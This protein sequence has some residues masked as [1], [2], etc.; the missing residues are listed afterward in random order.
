ML[1]PPASWQAKIDSQ[2]DL[3]EFFDGLLAL[4]GFSRSLGR[5]LAEH[6]KQENPEEDEDGRRD[7]ESLPVMPLGFQIVVTGNRTADL[8]EGG[9]QLVF[10]VRNPAGLPHLGKFIEVDRAIRLGVLAKVFPKV[11]DVLVASEIFD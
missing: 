1:T 3:R 4:G 9:L 5:L 7:E 8:I 2:R 10:G 11:E 6:D